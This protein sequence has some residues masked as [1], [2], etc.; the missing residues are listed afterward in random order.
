MVVLY[1]FYGILFGLLLAIVGIGIYVYRDSKKEFEKYL[2]RH[3]LDGN[4]IV[5][6]R[7]LLIDWGRVATRAHASNCV[8]NTY[9]VE[10]RIALTNH[11]FVK[12]REI[13]RKYEDW[14]MAHEVQQIR[15]KSA[16]N[17]L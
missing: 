4:D 1:I 14:I 8:N 17:D 2:T 11:K 10:F 9:I 16:G 13:L 6:L 15:Q 5:T 7:K 3:I 12:M